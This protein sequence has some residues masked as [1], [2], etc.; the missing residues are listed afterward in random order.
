M[1]KTYH[2]YID[3]EWVESE[4]GDMIVT[5]PDTEHTSEVVGGDPA[6]TTCLIAPARSSSSSSLYGDG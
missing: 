1:P 5:P 3:G 6:N 2:N 4:T